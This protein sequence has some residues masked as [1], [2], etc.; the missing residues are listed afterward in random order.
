M[1]RF[2]NINA[3]I[4]KNGS[5]KTSILSFIQTLFC[6]SSFIM[7]NSFSYE[8]INQHLLIVNKL[9]NGHKAISFE[10]NV[11]QSNYNVIEDINIIQNSILLISQSNSFSI[12]EDENM[13]AI[14]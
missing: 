3:I 12:Y 5:G 14:P 13:G 6:K 7:T 8:R 1:K 11:D 4:G 9:I 2:L 10:T